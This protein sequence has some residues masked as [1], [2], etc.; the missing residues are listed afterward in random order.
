MKKQLIKIIILSLIILFSFGF[1][2]TYAR[3]NGINIYINK[4]EVTSS[5]M[6]ID[7]NGTILVKAR[8]LSKMIKADINWINSINTLEL[9]NEEALIK[10]M[11]DQ[12]FMQIGNRTLKTTIGLVIRKDEAY[13]PLFRIAEAFGFI[14]EINREKN[15]IYL[16]EPESTINKIKWSDS[17]QNIIIDMNEIAPYR[18]D[19]SDDYKRLVLEI[20]NASLADDFVDEVSNKNFYVKFERKEDDPVLKVIIISKYPLPFKREGRILEEDNHLILNLMPAIEAV[21]WTENNLLNI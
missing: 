13:V 3:N 21:E 14:S 20:E 8:S 2:I 1:D 5:L 18:I 4:K 7:E 10:M 15:N 9:K 11:V 17:G 12:P 19:T 16:Y 6:P